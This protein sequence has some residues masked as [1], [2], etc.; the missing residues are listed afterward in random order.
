MNAQL[1]WKE[2]SPR[3]KFVFEPTDDTASKIYCTIDNYQEKYK[4]LCE[5]LQVV[6]NQKK[7][8]SEVCCICASQL[9][10]PNTLD[11][12][13]TELKDIVGG[14]YPNEITTSAIIH[15]QEMGVNESPEETEEAG[16]ATG[17]TNTNIQ[18]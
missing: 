13:E 15:Q 8:K 2:S 11:P 12:E 10:A 4:E 7:L 9:K 1:I 16:Y 17:T 14:S 6:L 3:C 18:V 5:T